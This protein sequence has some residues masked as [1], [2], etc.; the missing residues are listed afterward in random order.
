MSK[1]HCILPNQHNK[2]RRQDICLRKTSHCY[3][4]IQKIYLHKELIWRNIEAELLLCSFAAFWNG[5]CLC[6]FVCVGVCVCYHTVV[7]SVCLITAKAWSNS[8]HERV[9]T[10]LG[11]GITRVQT[12][13]NKH[14]THTHTHTHPHTSTQ[15]G[16]FFLQHAHWSS[17]LMA[18]W[19]DCGV[20]VS[21]YLHGHFK[22]IQPLLLQ[23]SGLKKEFK[24]RVPLLVSHV[25]P[26]APLWGSGRRQQSKLNAFSHEG[27]HYV[28][29]HIRG[30]RRET[31]MAECILQ[32]LSHLD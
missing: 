25:E 30:Y 23:L 26:V 13:T 7:S 32:W 1:Q 4:I 19:H 10:S 20:H 3:K 31:T 14:N 16:F 5:L 17:A 18:N 21:V 11:L 27:I 24:A 29:L 8:A 9:N 2:G 12:K 22:L 6:G 15:F 28:H